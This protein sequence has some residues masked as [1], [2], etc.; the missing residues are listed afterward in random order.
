MTMRKD[1]SSTDDLGEVFVI[2]VAAEL[3]GM[4]AQT[5]RTYDRMGLVSPQR[6]RGGGRRY[7]RP[8]DVDLTLG[9][10]LEQG[11][12]GGRCRREPFDEPAHDRRRQERL[13]TG[14]H[15]DRVDQVGR[16][17]VLEQEARGTG[18]QRLGDLLV[19]TEGHQHEDPA[20]GVRGGDP[21]GGLDAVQHGHPDVHQ[22][23]LGALAR[24]QVERLA[25]VRRLSDDLDGGRL[26][27]DQPQSGPDQGLVVDDR[28]RGHRA[29]LVAPWASRSVSPPSA[30]PPLRPRSGAE[31]P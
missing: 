7:Y 27:Q 6:T 8:Q 22:H 18:P 5:L 30:P 28:H 2:S 9:Q 12:A 11:R 4:H 14:H 26:V 17:D 1:K 10:R 13:A 21:P 19:L 3:A 23:H 31:S 29:L 25:P 16:V 20:A 15:G 24:D